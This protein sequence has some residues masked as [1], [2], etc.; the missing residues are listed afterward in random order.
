MAEDTHLTASEVCEVAG[1]TYR[2]LDDWCRTGLVPLANPTPG[3]GRRRQF[4]QAAAD[5]VIEIAQARRHVADLRKAGE[6]LARR[7]RQAQGLP[8]TIRDPEAIRRVGALLGR[9]HHDEPVDGD[10]AA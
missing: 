2:Q 3:Y 5:R 6:A 4:D 9:D 8:K 1:C 10:G 7:T